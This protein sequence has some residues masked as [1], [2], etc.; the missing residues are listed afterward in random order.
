MREKEI[1]GELIIKI[2]GELTIVFNNCTGQNKN[3]TVL[4]LI[5]FLVEMGYFKKVNFMFLVVWTYKECCRSP[6]QCLEVPVPTG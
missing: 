6:F 1:D 2:G 5:V 3:N 4:R